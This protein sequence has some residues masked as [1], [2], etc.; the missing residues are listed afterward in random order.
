MFNYA[1]SDTHFLL[2]CFDMLRNELL[3]RTATATDDPE[4]K[5][6]T[7]LARSKEVSLRRY[8]KEPYDAEGGEGAL[9]WRTILGRSSA[10]ASSHDALNPMELAVFKAV[11]R[12]RDTTARVEDESVNYVMPRHQLF[13]LARHAPTDI[14][15]VLACCSRPSPPL[16]LRAGELVLAIRTAMHSPEVREWQ[17]PPWPGGGGSHTA[18][19]AG[20]GGGA[21]AG[22][23][24]GAAAAAAAA[25]AGATATAATAAGATATA[26]ATTT[27]AAAAATHVTAPRI[28]VFA[29]QNN[30]LR[31][32]K[33]SFWGDGAAESSLW[34]EC[35]AAI[36]MRQQMVELRLA[37]PLPPLTA[38]VFVDHSDSRPRIPSK[39]A[40]PGARVAHEFVR[41]EQR[42]GPDGPDGREGDVVVVRSLG[43]RKLADAA[44]RDGA[45][46]RDSQ[47]DLDSNSGA[48]VSPHPADAGNDK[49]KKKEKREKRE[50]K[51]E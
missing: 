35:A 20:G 25:A 37:V 39:P 8:E 48:P 27:T 38:A 49:A 36:A 18:A 16:K 5:M 31:A 3:Q 23:G 1:R 28:D 2:Y 21:A 47:D 30:A 13:N 32:K 51:E 44:D 40:D 26:T 34:Q 12:W 46:S 9:G 41:K 33:S 15:G 10:S 42:D 19:A 11:H 43:K 4:S 6:D 29:S 7:V 45:C 22:G 14:A 17:S 50:K 24:G